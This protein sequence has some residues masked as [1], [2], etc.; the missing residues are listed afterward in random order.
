MAE[1]M[2]TRGVR[3]G[4]IGVNL[5]ANRGQPGS[6]LRLLRRRAPVRAAR[7]LSDRQRVV[8]QHAGLRELQ[9][10][11]ALPA[12]LTRIS[13]ARAAAAAD[14]GRR[15]PLL[16]KIAPDMTDA[17]LVELIGTA[18]SNGVDGLIIANTTTARPKLRSR[19][20]ASQLG[21]L[22]GK[23]L[24]EPS[25]AMIARARQIAG[26]DLVLVGRRRR[27]RRGRGMVENRRWGRS[28]AALYGARLRGP[29]AAAAYCRRPSAAAGGANIAD[30]RSVRGIET[31]RWAAAWSG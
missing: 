8:A 17:A 14:S 2:E 27:G 15:P 31:T 16:L 11:E 20:E 3:T 12:L 6:D 23:P 26:P 30:I 24:F 10:S 28:G 9:G 22:S 29:V 13:E 4:I 18:L 25:T 1:R 19:R 5:G 7:V 21:G